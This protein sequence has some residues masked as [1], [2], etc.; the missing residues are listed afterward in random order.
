[1]P[2]ILTCDRDLATMR[3]FTSS[4]QTVQAGLASPVV[5]IDTSHSLRLSAEFLVMVAGLI[6]RAIYIHPPE[7]CMSEY[8]SVQ[9]ASTFALKRALEETEGADQILFLEDDI[10]FSSRFL[11][12]LRSLDVP[13]DTGF[14]TFYLPDHEY[15]ADII[16]P[17]RFYGT[18][19]LLLPRR[20]VEE[21]VAQIEYI[22]AKFYPGYDIRWSRFLA[23]RGYRLY[24]T[25]QSYVQHLGTTSRLHRHHSHFSDCF[26]E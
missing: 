1:V 21:I 17:N 22:K 24:S 5:V 19:C 7:P 6:T 14:V 26:V 3:Q 20:A 4:F 13:A 11:E 9:E 15:G 12:K 10:V 23:E 18:Q 2:L 25:D 8:D 16:D